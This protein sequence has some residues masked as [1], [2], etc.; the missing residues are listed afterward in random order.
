MKKAKWIW[1]SGS[2][3]LNE[4]AEFKG[5]FKA[6]EGVPHTLEISVAGNYCAYL[7]GTVIAA[8]R[9][10]D[11]P[12]YK[13]YDAV[14]ITPFIR[15]GENE[16]LILAYSYGLGT[17]RNLPMTPALSAE[18]LCQGNIV[19]YT[20]ENTVCRHSPNYVGGDIPMMAN[21]NFFTQEIVFG[22]AGEKWERAAKAKADYK[23]FPRPIKRCEIGEVIPARLSA[24]GAF[25]ADDI[26]D[27]AEKLAKA[28]LSHVN[29]R[30][31]CG[32]TLRLNFPSKGVS[33]FAGGENMYFVFDLLKE[34]NGYL[35]FDF[36]L[37]APADIEIA[38]GEHLDD[39]RVRS[40]IGYRNFTSVIH[41]AKG[42]NTF[43]DYINRIGCRYVQVYVYAPRITIRYF[44]MRYVGYPVETLPYKAGD[45][46]RQKIYDVSV[47][48]LKECMHE[49]YEDCPWRE[50]A[51][52]FMDGRNQMLCGFYA[53][54]ETKFARASIDLLFRR[55]RENGLTYITAP[56]DIPLSI[57]S[58]TLAGFVMLR[59]YT[60][61]SK[62]LTLAEELMPT[63]EKVIQTF[64]RRVD[65]TGLITSFTDEDSAWNFYEWTEGLD[66]VAHLETVLAG[67]KIPSDGKEYPAALNAF[68]AAALDSVAE[69]FEKLGADA[70]RYRDISS[71]VKAAVSELL[72]DGER[73]CFAGYRK[74]D[75]LYFYGELPNALAL[76]CGAATDKQR[77]EA[78]KLL[79]SKDSFLK[80]LTLSMAMYKYQALIDA[81]A[82]L[83][84]YVFSEIDEKW[85]EML[86]HNATTFW[87]T[88]LGADDFD[89]A[90]SLCHGWSAIPIYF[91][92]KYDELPF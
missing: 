61:F 6:A 14:D 82:S 87:E 7:N 76:W 50:Q 92:A 18:V 15:E 45:A 52:Y 30:S 66:N 63:L 21:K 85:G 19:F 41:A 71:G 44:G 1:L 80:P 48:T 12:E 8:A 89:Y 25:R 22:R 75:K 28:W 43:T 20:D 53:F 47:R 10:D 36:D 27:R 58:F 65:G 40:K 62:D 60:A 4:Y 42:A 29:Q 70:Q 32:E 88:G 35:Y 23:L 84:D 38:Y 79:T 26:S 46:L 54:N 55:V 57:P 69:L 74:G 16:L 59:D 49:H 68:F 5:N 90:G 91:Y 11:F 13:F 56:T 39:L 24:Q 67:G 77:G 31:M 83:K 64:I 72:W 81:D 17:F 37:E 86:F 3:G 34:S 51:L 2:Y 9:F 78:V 33:F 73:N